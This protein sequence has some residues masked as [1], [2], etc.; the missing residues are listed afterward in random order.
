[1]PLSDDQGMT[2]LI[3]ILTSILLI[4]TT[5][6][7]TAPAPENDQIRPSATNSVQQ[8]TGHSVPLA[9]VDD[10]AN[11][12]PSTPSTRPALEL[13]GISADQAAAVRRVVG[14]FEQANLELPPLLVRSGQDGDEC[15]QHLGLHR[16]HESWS[17][18]VLCKSG[19]SG[20]ERS[21]VVHELA[22][23]WAA[24]EL[25]DTNKAAFQQVRGWEHWHDYENAAWRDNGTEQAA[26]VI[27]WGVY[28]LAATIAIGHHGC[29]DLAES[30]RAL[31]GLDPAQGITTICEPP[32][33]PVF[34]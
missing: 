16:Q 1:M 20:F 26:E 8:S 27:A 31:T 34:S 5:T 21:V 13:I 9:D 4:S 3:N 32:P 33:A 7:G 15:G 10:E 2:S 14:L 17:E 29:A 28:D 6:T 22:H 23:A 12:A 30:Y 25:S 19:S 24:F 18:I 11:L